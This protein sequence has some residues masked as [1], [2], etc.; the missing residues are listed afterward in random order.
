MALLAL[1]DDFY[2]N[3]D[4]IDSPD[5]L[6]AA[7]TTICRAAGIRHFAISHHLDFSRPQPG[8]LHLHNYPPRFAAFHDREGFGARDPVHRASRLRNTGFDW[9]MLS[10][11]LRMDRQDHDLFDRAAEAGIGDGYTVPV[12][13]PGEP[14]GSCSF[15][16]QPG[17]PFPRDF[18]PLAQGLGLVAFDVARR[19]AGWGG[20]RDDPCQLTPRE[21]EIVVLLGQGQ[22]EK[23]IARSLGIS[24]V[25]V[26]DHLKHAR[27][28][29]G[30]HKSTQLVVRAIL[31]GVITESELTAGHPASTG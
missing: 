19:L 6:I 5:R 2:R 11:F 24:P 16:T 10:S 1:I 13:V 20:R 22:R 15:A 26:N 17:T 25:T 31:S 3:I 12:H 23:Q 18:I 28:R 8:A 7:L 4:R 21:R 9:S 27:E 29:C 14:C 30:V